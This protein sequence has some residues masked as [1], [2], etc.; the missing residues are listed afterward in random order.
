MRII[1]DVYPVEIAD[2]ET[3]RLAQLCV[4]RAANIEELQSLIGVFRQRV[5]AKEEHSTVFSD[6]LAGIIASIE[7]MEESCALWRREIEAMKV[8]LK[9]RGE[10]GSGNI[11]STAR[12]AK[13]S[14]QDAMTSACLR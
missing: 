5:A 12:A 3:W 8:E 13:H 6:N 1:C 2:L 14:T 7:D 9:K 10:G 11:I 4:E